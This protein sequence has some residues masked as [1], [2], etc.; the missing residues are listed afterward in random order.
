MANA[1]GIA[2]LMV[3]TRHKEIAPLFMGFLEVGLMKIA[4]CPQA[5]DSLSQCLR[6]SKG[7]KACG[8]PSSVVSALMMMLGGVRYMVW[9]LY[10]KPGRTAMVTCRLLSEKAVEALEKAE[11]SETRFPVA[12]AT[13]NR[14]LERRRCAVAVL[15]VN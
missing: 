13:R 14:V 3:F 15:L 7:H 10:R 9:F 6:A 11:S 5:D 2:E 8:D 12:S 4:S 1:P